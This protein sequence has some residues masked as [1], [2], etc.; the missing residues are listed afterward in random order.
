ML[1]FLS[2]I[3]WLGWCLIVL[4]AFTIWQLPTITRQWRAPR[5]EQ[6][7][8]PGQEPPSSGSGWW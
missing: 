5:D 6:K 3:S 4:A 1:T 2:S 8:N 7:M